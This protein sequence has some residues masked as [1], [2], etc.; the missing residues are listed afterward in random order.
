[1]SAWKERDCKRRLWADAP[2]RVDGKALSTA[3]D[4]DA[5]PPFRPQAETRVGHRGPGGR[6]CVGNRPVPLRWTTDSMEPKE[7]A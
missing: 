2:L 3:A 4:A 1:M 7:A 6:A 5:A